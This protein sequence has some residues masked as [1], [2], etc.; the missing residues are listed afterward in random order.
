MTTKQTVLLIIGGLLIFI[1]GGGLGVV[2]QK[3]QPALI[4]QT[5]PEQIK[6]AETC[7]SIEKILSSKNFGELPA[8]GVV[9][10]ISGRDITLS[11]GGDSLS[12]SQLRTAQKYIQF[13][14]LLKRLSPGQKTSSNVEPMMNTFDAIKVGQTLDVFTS[15]SPDGHI[16][17]S[18]VTIAPTSIQ[19]ENNS[20]TAK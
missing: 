3:Q 18:S 8:V 4:I 15:V 10:K 2:Y 16:G 7:A 6:E 12:A 9:T 19:G 17:I 5:T 14:H 13:F 11:Y 1:V 20:N